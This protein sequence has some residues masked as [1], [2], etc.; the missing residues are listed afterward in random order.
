MFDDS[1]GLEGVILATE[2]G[3]QVVEPTSLGHTPLAHRLKMVDMAAATTIEAAVAKIPPPEPRRSILVDVVVEDVSRFYQIFGVLGIPM[4]VAFLL[5][6]AWTVMLAVIQVYTTEIAN[7]LMNTSSFDNGNFWLLPKP[8]TSLVGASVTLLVLFGLGYLALA[9]LMLYFSCRSMLLMRGSNAEVPA[10][11]VDSNGKVKP[12][13]HPIVKPQSRNTALV[14]RKFA[15]RLAA[16]T[17]E[18]REY[19]VRFP[20]AR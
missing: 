2:S 7:R 11:R 5:S 3:F 19:V 8:P 14:L 10:K 18:K 15:C 12:T 6:A 16:M 17:P 1:T 9:A 13:T 4:F 20:G